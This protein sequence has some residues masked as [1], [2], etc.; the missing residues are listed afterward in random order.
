MGH[1]AYHQH[2]E[3]MRRAHKER[4]VKMAL[5]IASDKSL[6]L[7]DRMVAFERALQIFPAGSH[8]HHLVTEAEPQLYQEYQIRHASATQTVA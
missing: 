7:N 2:Q 1:H 6:P 4:A 3:L 8:N 5:D